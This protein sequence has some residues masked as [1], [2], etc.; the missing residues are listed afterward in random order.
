MSLITSSD[1]LV[2]FGP[3]GM[4]GSA[5]SRALDR[6]AYQHELRPGSTEFDLFGFAAVQH[7]AP[8]KVGNFNANST[9]LVYFPR[10]NIKIQSYVIETV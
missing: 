10:E 1:P 2:V 6:T 3:R 8:A 7:R 5:I 4:A 9:Y